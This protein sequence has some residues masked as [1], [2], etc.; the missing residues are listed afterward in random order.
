M[1]I[2]KKRL[3]SILSLL[4]RILNHLTFHKCDS[5]NQSLK[6]KLCWTQ[7]EVL[8]ITS[9]LMICKIT[10]R[11]KVLK[12]SEMMIFLWKSLPSDLTP[13]LEVERPSWSTN[14]SLTLNLTLTIEKYNW[15]WS[16]GDWNHQRGKRDNS[17]S[18]PETDMKKLEN[19]KNATPNT[20]SLFKIK[21][22]AFNKSDLL[23]SKQLKWWTK[24]KT[25]TCRK[26]KN[27]Y[28]SDLF[29]QL[30]NEFKQPRQERRTMTLR[31]SCS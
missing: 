13:M 17:L 29:L 12:T 8:S 4:F 22:Q 20:F 31:S 30:W 2:L 11:I 21:S 6:V 10:T 14:S 3:K 28:E 27:K 23:P 7:K 1:T 24:G 5:S 26:Q 25:S 16:K 15:N 18:T 9:I 19:H